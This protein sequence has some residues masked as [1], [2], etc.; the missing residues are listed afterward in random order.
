MDAEKIISKIKGIFHTGT[1]KKD[2]RCKIQQ[3]DFIAALICGI[4]HQ[5]G[6]TKSLSALRK[7]I[8]ESTKCLL[9]RGAFWERMASRKLTKSLR[10]LLGTLISEIQTK[11]GISRLTN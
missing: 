4:P 8:G 7:A 10:K 5:D 3:Q 1:Q 2:G 11:L 6:R 9:S